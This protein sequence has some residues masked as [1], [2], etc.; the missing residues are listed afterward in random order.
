M[1]AL[2]VFSVGLSSVL[3]WRLSR[4]HMKWGEF[5]ILNMVLT[6]MVS[7]LWWVSFL[8]F[9]S[10]SFSFSFLPLLHNHIT[11]ICLCSACYFLLTSTRVIFRGLLSCLCPLYEHLLELLKEVASSQPMPYLKD[12]V[13]P[14]CVADFLG[15]SDALTLTLIE[16]PFSPGAK[17]EPPLQRKLCVMV[18]NKRKKQ[19]DLGIAVE[20]RMKFNSYFFYFCLLRHSLIN[21]LNSCAI[22]QYFYNHFVSLRLPFTPLM[23]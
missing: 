9:F 12:A 21:T 23:E 3:I 16:P 14:E 2:P 1:T 6:S 22:P 8:V 7:R 13:L 20:R 18:K 4:R 19:E 11:T 15:P 5:I 10:F 17:V